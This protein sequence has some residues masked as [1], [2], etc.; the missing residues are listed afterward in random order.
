[1]QAGAHN[2]SWEL[3]TYTRVPCMGSIL[4]KGYKENDY[5]LV[6]RQNN[7]VKPVYSGHLWTQ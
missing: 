6:C 7:T 5:C 4:H 1:M 3:H 2:G